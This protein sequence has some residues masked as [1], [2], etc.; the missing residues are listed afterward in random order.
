MQVKQVAEELGVRYVLEG[1]VRRAGDQLRINAQLIDAT[2]G[3]HLWAER[4]DGQMDNVFALQDKITRKIV[5][6]LAVQLTA[7]DEKQVAGKETD[8]AEAYDTFLKGWVHYRRGTPDDF[9]Q[10]ISYFEKA[11]ELDPNYSRAYAALAAIYW[12]S[13]R[14][15]WRKLWRRPGNT[16]RKL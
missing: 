7:G 5:S 14:Y 2:T 11:V 1:S 15:G 3:G 9:V 4:Y 10:A 16:C 13:A 12:K 8:S 6:A